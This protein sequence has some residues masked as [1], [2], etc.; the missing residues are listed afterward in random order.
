MDTCDIDKR[1]YLLSKVTMGDSIVPKRCTESYLIKNNLLSILDELVEPEFGSVSDRIKKLKYGGGYCLVCNVRTGLHISGRGFSIYC[2]DHAT[3][4]NKGKVAHN[5]KDVDIELIKKLYIEEN[6]SIIEISKVL[7]DVSNVTIK[8]K[9][10][11]AGIEIRPHSDNQ[12]IKA[13]RGIIKPIIKIDREELV[14]KY[15]EKKIPM[16]ILS[17][18]Y[19]CHEETIRRFLKQEKVDISHRRY[20]IEYII[21]D[22]LDRNN[23]SYKLNDRKTISP[24]E[25]DFLLVDDGIGI[26][27][28]GMYHHSLNKGSKD[29]F[30]HHSKYK[31]SIGNGL[32][33]LQFWEN[34]ILDKSDIIEN[35]IQ[36][37]IGSLEF[38]I[39]ARKCYIVELDYIS[40]SKFCIDNHIQG[41]PQISTKGY[42]LVYNNKLVSVLGYVKNK[43]DII[44]NRFCSLKQHNVIGGFSKLCNR[45]K[46][47]IITY[48]HN[49]ISNGELYLK[50]GFEFVSENKADMW[51]TDYK[52]IYNRQEFMKNKLK[53]RFELFDENKTEIENIIDNGY[54]IIYK[55]G[56]KKW[57]KNTLS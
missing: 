40:I 25:I 33:L 49:D 52:K 1:E 3:E 13:K 50:T 26:E 19:N 14:Y 17:K 7:G 55:S 35:I 46:G 23:I 21:K 45:L 43:E 27:A 47:K 15:S 53:S 37:K 30:Y 34:D 12:K 16:S 57:M 54:D 44:I 24:Y 51:V 18:E 42:G 11:E 2:K 10:I 20:N 36:S 22:I 56:T 31:N 32:R 5:R 28:N 38:K 48:S 6:K 39:Y 4:S 8:K 41:S 29:K 9:M